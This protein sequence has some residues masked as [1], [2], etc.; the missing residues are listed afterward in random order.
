MRPQLVS[1]VLVVAA[2]G[3]RPKPEP[4][5]HSPAATIDD[6]DD[7][8]GIAGDGD[9]DLPPRPEGTIYRSEL[10]RGTQDGNPAY[11]LSQLGPEAYR[12]QGRFEGW[13]ITRVWPSDPELCAP[14]ATSDRETSCS[15]STDHSFVSPKSSARCS[16]S[17]TRSR[18][19]SCV[20]FGTVSTSS[21]AS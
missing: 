10:A 21:A 9:T 20:G 7:N 15:R 19:S 2:L 18:P 4:A 11:L 12:P 3:C 14:V 5:S 6:L 17:S 13:L 8:S 1:L 16:R